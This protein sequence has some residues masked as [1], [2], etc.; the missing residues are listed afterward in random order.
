[1]VLVECAFEYARNFQK[2]RNETKRNG[3]ERKKI[4]RG[5]LNII[6]SLPFSFRLIRR[7]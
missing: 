5:Q 2:E 6:Q 4:E 1:M 3:T 7:I